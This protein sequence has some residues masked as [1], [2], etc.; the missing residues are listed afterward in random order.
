MGWRRF[1][2]RLD[3]SRRSQALSEVHPEFMHCHASF[4]AA[5]APPGSGLVIFQSLGRERAGF[6]IAATGN[7]VEVGPEFNVVKKLKLVG[8]A[9][10]VYSNAAFL[11]EMFN[12][13]LEATLYL[14]ASIRTVSGIRGAIKKAVSERARGTADESAV[15]HRYTGA[16][17]ATFENRVLLSDIVFLRAWVPVEPQRFCTTATTMLNPPEDAWR[18]RT[19]REVRQG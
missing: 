4:Y 14:S 17:R 1:Q 10:K 19:T 8:E 13:E 9:C 15:A 3:G 12:S 11:K 5:A 18:M 16:F 6:R 2:I 7:V